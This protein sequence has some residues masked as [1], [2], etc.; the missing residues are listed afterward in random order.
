[1]GSVGRRNAPVDAEKGRLQGAHVNTDPELAPDE[2][3]SPELV[4]VL[5]AALRAEV[6][7]AL[8]PPVRPTPRPLAPAPLRTVPAARPVRQPVARPAP[9]PAARPVA[10]PVARSVATLLATRLTQLALIFVV[11]AILTLAMSLVAQAFR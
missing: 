9:R 6:L 11:V 7:A 1:M 2:P 3:L 10:I 8:A 4:L 5:P